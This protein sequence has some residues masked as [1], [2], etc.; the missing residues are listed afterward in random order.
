MVQ[1]IFDTIGQ[2]V[3]GLATSIGT[4]VTNVVSMFWTPAESG[5][6]GSFTFLGTILLVALGAGLVYFVIRLILRSIRSVA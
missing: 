6:G 3:T 5:N 1:S 4:A 2:A